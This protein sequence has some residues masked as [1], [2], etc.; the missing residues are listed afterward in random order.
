M[1]GPIRA[2]A[3]IFLAVLAGSLGT[4]IAR[5]EVVEEIVAKVN[6]DIITRSDLQDSEQELLSDLYRQYTGKELDDRVKTAKAGLLINLID[7]KILLHRAQRLFDMDKMGDNLLSNF[8]EDRKIKSDDEL[9]KMLDQDHM[10]IADL[11]KKLVE[12]TAPEQVLGYE[13]KDRVS[14]GDKEVEAFYTEHPEESEVP[15]VATLREIVLLA[16]GD[17]KQARRAE[18]E[19]LR[20]RAAAPGADFEAL[21]REFSEAGT[22]ASGGLIA[23]VKKGELA[24][25]LEQVAFTL[26]PGQVSQVLDTPY[27]FHIIKV[28][29]RAEPQKRSLEDLRAN[30]KEKL[31]K[32]RFEQAY[33]DFMKK[34][35]KEAEIWVSPKYQSRIAPG[36][37]EP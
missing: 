11:K 14:V 17:K 34:A 6:D 16:E 22:K 25:Q 18:A 24:A 3:G 31:Y 7:R 35:R 4:G 1:T 19:R 36:A 23:D 2:G 12:W 15:A 10:T 13:V 26:A 8:R 32:A 29:S 9:K 33:N 27:G 30:L 37:L 21:A 28:E 20:E 5:G